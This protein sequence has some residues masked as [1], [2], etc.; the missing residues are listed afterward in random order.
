MDGSTW[1]LTLSIWNNNNEAKNKKKMPANI[2]TT[3]LA[4]T[5]D[6]MY[7]LWFFNF[8]RYFYFQISFRDATTADRQWQE[9]QKIESTKFSSWCNSPTTKTTT[10]FQAS[11]KPQKS[12][13]QCHQ[14]FQFCFF[15]QNVFILLLDGGGQILSV[16]FLQSLSF[17]IDF[18]FVPI[19]IERSIKLLPDWVMQMTW[20]FAINNLSILI[21]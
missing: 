15:T 12:D 2:V 13:I 1:L 11:E 21:V 8:F 18:S 20:D 3:S 9:H 4:I 17:L 10:K 7:Q 14:F 6:G 19:G 16:C 5:Q